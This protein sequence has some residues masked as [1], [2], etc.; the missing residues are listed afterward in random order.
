MPADD[1]RLNN[2]SMAA[3]R[4]GV[5]GILVPLLWTFA[6]FL[7]FSEEPGRAV[8][9]GVFLLGLGSLLAW[10][11]TQTPLW[12]AFRADCVVVRTLL[13]KRSYDI[14]E[15]ARVETG[16]MV[17]TIGGLGTRHYPCVKIILKRGRTIRIN[18]DPE[19]AA[20]VQSRLD[21]A[22]RIRGDQ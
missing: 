19:V 9:F 17:S 12:I 1:V 7:I 16:R 22:A 4:I 20:L 10:I 13:G 15:I 5:A 14:G 2:Y 3:G 8:A 6:T 18:A 21:K 11:T